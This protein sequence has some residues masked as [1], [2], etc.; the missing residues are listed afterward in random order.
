M[1]NIEDPYALV[2]RNFFGMRVNIM[3]GV[4]LQAGGRKPKHLLYHLCHSFVKN[5]GGTD[6]E[7][8]VNRESPLPNIFLDII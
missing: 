1:P 6:L 7:L 8:C 2:H 5:L 3:I 4:F